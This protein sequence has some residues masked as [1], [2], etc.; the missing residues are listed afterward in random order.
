MCY[1]GTHQVKCYPRLCV[2]IR[3]KIYYEQY[4]VSVVVVKIIRIFLGTLVTKGHVNFTVGYCNAEANLQSSRGTLVNVPPKASYS[5]DA[6]ELGD[7]SF[8]PAVS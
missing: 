7:W 1:A 6:V 4:L 2:H 3:I 8:S 5:V